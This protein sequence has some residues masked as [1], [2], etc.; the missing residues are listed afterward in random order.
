LA[1]DGSE[2]LRRSV[3]S[4][5][6]RDSA[7]A[8]VSRR[9]AELLAFSAA[10][11]AL[12]RLGLTL[13]PVHTFAA[14]VWAPT[15]ISVAAVLLGGTR[16]WPGIALGAFLANAWTGAPVPVAL[17]IA[18]GNTLEA[19]AGA[20]LVRRL[21][22]FDGTLDGLRAALALAAAAVCATAVSATVGAAA[23]LAGGAIR[24]GAFA[25]AWRVW[26]LGDA[27]GLLIVGALLLAWGGAR[28][29][30]PSPARLAEAAGMVAAVAGAGSLVFFGSPAGA[31]SGFLQACLLAPLVAWGALRFGTRGATAAVFV[32]SAIAVAGTALG[33]GP[34]VQDTVSRSLLALQTFLA[35]VALTALVL[36]AVIADRAAALRGARAALDEQLRARRRAER[37][38]DAL[39]EA[40]RRKDEFLG[41]L[42][43]ELR[44]P[45][46][47]I[48]NALHLLGRAPAGSDEA[49]RARDVVERQVAHLV[50]LVDD[51]LDVTR[52]SQGKIRLQLS[53]LDLS[54]LVREVAA[55][56]RPS[57]DARGVAFEVRADAPSWVDGDRTRLAQVLGNLLQ[58]AVK[59]TD[60][61][62]HV[63]AE[64]GGEA[65]G[66]A[67]LRVRDDGIGIAPELLPHV[68]EPFTQ[69]DHSLDRRRGGLGLGLAF[70]KAIVELHGGE[71]E[72]RSGPGR[73]TELVVT[74]RGAP[75]PPA[76]VAGSP[77]AAPAS[78]RR[79]VLI[80]EDNPDTAETLKDVLELHDQEV[81]VARDGE[82]GLARVWSLEP[83]VVLCD[84]GLPGLDGYEV[85]RRIRA[86]ASAGP[87]L[88][89][90]TG[91][92]LP[93][94]RR[95]ALEAGFDHHLAKPFEFSELERILA[96]EPR[97]APRPSGAGE[98]SPYRRRSR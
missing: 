45:L 11:V 68:F 83:D 72:V 12:A 93:E 60:A 53:R 27:A 49:H 10:Y 56:H 14:P 30:R 54:S 95:R 39:R 32:V 48:R 84:V 42:S 73:G 55:D 87:T 86:E 16:F 66:R 90:L 38:E 33:R 22:G 36:G 74:L 44:N 3:A 58:N 82:E 35:V 78:R 81:A 50:R 4:L 65:S 29:D 7:A 70:A 94:D 26:W 24:P 6:G 37:A 40:D 62:G 9:F 85:A 69:G 57:F 64:V 2:A 1:S 91:Y 28:L 71:I 41:V 89:A 19:I 34:F 67:V 52:I 75:G 59:F 77:A 98:D 23:L 80:V 47:P 31:A 43:H 8:A 5:A 13:G 46:A 15:G 79:R 51:L 76:V 20:S 88:V 63:A 96:A 61:G 97:P 18:A 17:A 92:A 21:G 25:E